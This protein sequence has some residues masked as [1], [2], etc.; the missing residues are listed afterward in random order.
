M[1]TAGRSVSAAFRLQSNRISSCCRSC[2]SSRRPRPSTQRTSRPID[3]PFHPIVRPSYQQSFLLPAGC[4]VQPAAGRRIQPVREFVRSECESDLA[5]VSGPAQP[6]SAHSNKERSVRWI[7]GGNSEVAGRMAMR[8]R[9]LGWRASW[10]D[11]QS[12]RSVYRVVRYQIRRGVTTVGN[13]RSSIGALALQHDW[14]TTRLRG[15]ADRMVAR[16]CDRSFL[17]C[18][19]T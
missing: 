9:W 19:W 17:R 3:A 13:D 15:D 14:S 4:C 18:C 11:A 5:S 16:Y 8:R 1:D 7:R 2:R 12:S 10:L 6:K